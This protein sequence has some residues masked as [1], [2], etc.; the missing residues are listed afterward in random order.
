MLEEASVLPK[1]VLTLSTSKSAMMQ[2]TGESGM[3][4]RMVQGFS[5]PT[6]FIQVCSLQSHP[7]FEML[8][9]IKPFSFHRMSAVLS[10]VPAA[11]VFGLAIF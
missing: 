10:V 5:I 1:L 7:Y 4:V 8:G 9:I 6:Q 2:R 3:A 11:Q